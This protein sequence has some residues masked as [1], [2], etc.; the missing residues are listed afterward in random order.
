MH[1]FIASWNESLLSDWSGTIIQSWRQ[2]ST[3]W[4]DLLSSVTSGAAESLFTEEL[5]EL[6]C[7]VG[8]TTMRQGTIFI[9]AKKRKAA[10]YR[11]KIKNSSW[12]K[13]SDVQS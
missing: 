6:W 13:D 3:L 4:A 2:L 1:T 11:L 8:T 9:K 10:W 5:C 12:A 7:S